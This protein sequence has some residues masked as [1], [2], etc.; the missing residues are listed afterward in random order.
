M[1]SACRLVSWNVDRLAPLLRGGAGPPLAQVASAMGSPDIL[2]LQEIGLRPADRDATDAMRA[3][4]PGHDCGFALNRDDRN[5]TFRG[6][7]MY[8]VATYVRDGMAAAHAEVDWDREG[9]VLVTTFAE[10]GFAVVNVYAVNGT[11]KPYYDHAL[12]RIDGDRHTYKR[13]FIERLAAACERL[14]ERGLLLVL[15]GDWNVSRTS[16]DTHPRLRT[17]EPHALARAAFNERFIPGLDLADAFRELHPE[18]RKYTWFNRRAPAEKLDAAR[19]DYALVSRALMP[20][21][22]EADI[23]ERPA[24]R[25]ASDHAPLSL[26][27][28]LSRSRD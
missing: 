7:R 9:R 15:V 6:G 19:V 17:E 22:F 25:F 1:A 3:A 20:G 8:G 10:L 26:A 14:R 28:T 18:A 4:L 5:A 23:D 12:G 2:C 21:V 13:R 24:S 27:W 16:M 11:S